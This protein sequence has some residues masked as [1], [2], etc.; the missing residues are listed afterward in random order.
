V[1]EEAARLGIRSKRRVFASGKA[2]GGGRLSR[3]QVHFLLTN[4]VYLGRI[5]HR[6]QS[7]PGQHEA[8][9][10]EAL[11]ERVQAKL[12]EAAARPRGRAGSAAGA[13]QA[14]APSPLAGRFRDETG[15]RLTPT[16]TRRHGRR[17]RYYVSNRLVSGRSSAADAAAWR[18]P[19]P[20]FETSVAT[21]IAGHLGALAERHA[22]LAAPDAASL[23]ALAAR[24]GELCDRL[25]GGDAG[26]LRDLVVSGEVGH[27]RIAIRLAPEA[28]AAELGTSPDAIA[29]GVPAIT[30]PFHLRRRG[31]ETRIVAG[32][33]EPAPDPVLVR[34]LAEARHW[35]ARLRDGVPLATLSRQ[36]GHSDAYIRTRA[37][38]AFLSPRIQAAIVQGTQPPDLTLARILR[39]GVPLDWAEQERAFGFADTPGEVS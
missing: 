27:G 25:R 28:L 24:A 18:L 17:H 2:R 30:A 1:A 36:A 26:L 14:P 6:Q 10:D 7:F 32:D 12:Q 23:Q 39:A 37:Q 38:L 9:V 33:A 21:V 4:P 11:W 3:G 31:V 5:R 20:A 16:H 8:I 19:A 15:D 29:G 13:G 35:V 34:R 22:I